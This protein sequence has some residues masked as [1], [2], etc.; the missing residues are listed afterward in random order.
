MLINTVHVSVSSESSTAAIW[1]R[2]TLKV[3]SWIKNVHGFQNVSAFGFVPILNEWQQHWSL[4]EQNLMILFSN[5]I[6]DLPD[7][8]L[9]FCVS[10][11][12]WQIVYR[13][14][15][16]ISVTDLALSDQKTLKS[17]KNSVYFQVWIRWFSL[18]TFV[19]KSRLNYL[20]IKY[21]KTVFTPFIYLYLLFL[22]YYI[23]D[24]IY[25][26]S[27]IIYNYINIFLFY[28]VYIYI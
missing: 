20:N 13:G 7:G 14:V 26:I 17:W 15:L 6:W 9:C 8:F 4:H 18:W 19:P 21:F 27:L 16:M 25:E 12:I 1:C 28:I 22:I 23:W 3:E 10:K 2:I 5:M 24:Y 11:K